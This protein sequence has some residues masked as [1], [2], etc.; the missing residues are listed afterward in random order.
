M[1]LALPANVPAA[2]PWSPVLRGDSTSIYRWQSTCNSY[3][4]LRNNQA[5][6]VDPGD[7]EVLS[8]LAEIGVE[9]VNMILLTSHHRERLQ[10]IVSANLAGTL[11]AGPQAERALLENPTSFRKWYPTLGDK[12]SVYGASYVRPPRLPITLG[13]ALTDGKTLTWQDLDI[14]CLETPG[15]SPGGMTYLVEVDGKKVAF[16]G[17]VMH[18]GSKLVNWFDTEWDYGFAKGLDTLIQSVA[19]LT[20]QRPEIFFPA[21][22]PVIHDAPEQLAT[23]R[24]KL[25]RFREKYVR[26]YPVFGM[27]NKQRDPISTR[28]KVPGLNQVTPHLFKLGD[29]EK[30]WNFAI[31]ISDEGHGLILDAGL[32]PAAKL[33]EL[34]VGMREHLGLKKIDAFWIS[35]MHGDHFLQGP[36]LR[37][38]YGAES[39][40][41]DRIVDKIENPRRYDYAAL[42]SA[43]GAGI[44]GMPIDK[45]FR[46]GESV[47]WQGYQVQVDWMPGQTEFGCSLWLDIDDQ[48][49][50]FTG[51]N[52]FGDPS[53]PDQNG[54]EAVVARNSCIFEEGYLQGSK[55]LLELKPDIVMGSHS[56]VMPNPRAFLERYHRWAGEIIEL[57]KD[58][59]PGDRYE[60]RFDPYWVSAYPYR[61]DLTAENRRTVKI[62][63][64]N[65]RD[66]PQQHRVEF[67][68]PPGVQVEPAILEGTVAAESRETFEVV[69][70]SDP[71]A[72]TSDIGI[73]AMEI[74][75]DDDRYGEWF[76]FL[77]RTKRSKESDSAGP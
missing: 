72:T 74:T 22:G 19:G 4:I 10:G 30:G 28:T 56:Y 29:A 20:E 26:G 59:L 76:D 61:V 43:Y 40:T 37:E 47:D 62:T 7:G 15:N 5:L 63:I 48:R 23:Y 38:K 73:V 71:T 9:R 41:L 21:Y 33:E 2:E 24:E 67:K 58:L 17:G 25:A 55:Y 39:W 77:V 42:V 12:Y 14:T 18:D 45:A 50:V 8:R 75:L 69:V 34:I 16:S 68:P 35:H 11:V 70:T 60:Y 51:D 1:L 54:H 36:L 57:Y 13:Q 52:L 46:A 44:D 65:F 27:T 31:I 32:L 64:R 3:V 66:R 6:I 53:D 49:I